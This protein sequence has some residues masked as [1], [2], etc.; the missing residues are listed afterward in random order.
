MPKVLRNLI[1]DEISL[2]DV[3]ANPGAQVLLFKRD[4]SKEQD[5]PDDA[6]KGLTPEQL[7]TVDKAEKLLKAHDDLST[8]F[9]K[10]E[11]EREFL[12]TELQKASDRLKE[13][14]K[15]AAENDDDDEVVK[16]ELPEAVRKQIEA[17]EQ[18]SSE[19]KKRI[20]KM[21]EEKRTSEY[22]AKAEIL[23]NLPLVA[24]EFGP[25]LMRVAL[26]KSTDEDIE[27]LEKVLTA[28]NERADELLKVAGSDTPEANE[29]S[30]LVKLEKAAAALIDKDPELSEA[31]AFAKATERNPALY[32]QYLAERQ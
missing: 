28:A 32:T 5:M 11:E 25:V 3:P 29:G 19:L 6:I 12:K 18:E 27:A 16:V 7:E 24:K 31:T 14:E 30:A 26:N 8:K 1:L 10:L 2:V 13:L 22:I 9:E 17:T 4:T 15:A 20:E 23:K 21:E